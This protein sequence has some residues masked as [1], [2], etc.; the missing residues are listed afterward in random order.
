MSIQS[1]VEWEEDR[2][3]LSHAL[4]VIVTAR[5]VSQ[6]AITQVDHKHF[7]RGNL[8]VSRLLSLNYSTCISV[9]SYTYQSKIM[10]RYAMADS[11]TKINYIFRD[12]CSYK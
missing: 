1:A 7:V 2:F 6:T 9:L 12:A 3:Y 5:A 8:A 11:N 4:P 10:Q